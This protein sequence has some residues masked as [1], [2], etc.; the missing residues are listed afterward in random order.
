MWDKY[1]AL[2]AHLSGMEDAYNGVP[3]FKGVPLEDCQLYFDDYMTGWDQGMDYL[4]DDVP[5]PNPTL[6][7]T[8]KTIPIRG[9]QNVLSK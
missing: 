9:E 1:T 8:P 6:K 7:V 3:M 5:Y 4:R 2:A